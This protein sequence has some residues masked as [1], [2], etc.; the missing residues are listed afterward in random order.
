[1]EKSRPDLAEVIEVVTEHHRKFAQAFAKNTYFIL[2]D[3]QCARVALAWSNGF[4]LWEKPKN[5]INNEPHVDWKKRPK[6]ALFWAW[7]GTSID[8]DALA[9]AAG[10]P[11]ATTIAR[12]RQLRDAQLILPDGSLSEWS[13]TALQTIVKRM[14]QRAARKSSKG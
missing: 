2:K 11:L 1:M 13:E 7:L 10:I 12:F 3:E 9:T 4:T 14:L 6:R 5:G 8:I